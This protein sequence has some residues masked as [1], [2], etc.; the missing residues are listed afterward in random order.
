MMLHLN[1]A[2]L[3]CHLSDVLKLCGPLAVNQGTYIPSES[4]GTQL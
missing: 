2:V 1:F 3:A 4:Y